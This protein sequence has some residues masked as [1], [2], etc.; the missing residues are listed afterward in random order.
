[1]LTECRSSTLRRGANLNDGL[2][3]AASRSTRA[4]APDFKSTSVSLWANAGEWKSAGRPSTKW[5]RRNGVNAKPSPN[6]DSANWSRKRGGCNALSSRNTLASIGADIGPGSSKQW[7]EA[8]RD[9]GAKLK[10]PAKRRPPDLR[11]AVYCEMLLKMSW[12]RSNSSW[13]TYRMRF[14]ISR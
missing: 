14:L 2:S 3:N 8:G 11:K 6:T 13:K 12:N 1:M 10:S 9:Q 7:P 4:R 5:P